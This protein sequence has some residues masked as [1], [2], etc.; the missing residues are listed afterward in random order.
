MFNVCEARTYPIL[1]VVQEILDAAGSEAELVRV[2]NHEL[3]EDLGA[4][5]A[6]AQPL[7]VS[8]EKLSRVLGFRESPRAEAMKATVEWHLENPPPEP[9]DGFPGFEA[10][11]EA[12]TKVL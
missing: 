11:E 10:D 12:L 8:S 2:P 5:G 7:L 9:E 6:V 1:H 3:P 4:T